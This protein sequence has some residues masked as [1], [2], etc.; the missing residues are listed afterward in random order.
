MAARVQIMASPSNNRRRAAFTLVEIMIVVAIIGICAAIALPAFAKARKRGQQTTFINALR[1][2]TDAAEVYM[3]NTGQYLEDSDSGQVP[4]GLE[5]YIQSG[6]WTCGS[7]VGGL[8]DCELNENGITS[9]IGVDFSGGGNPG[10]EFM[11][12]IDELY[13]D[14]DLTTGKFRKIAENR[15]YDI[16]EE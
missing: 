13:D 12:E 14:G 4:S 5:A 10:E 3:M 1:V 9:A 8:W 15:Y 6:Q 2:F 7:P 16:L 11:Q